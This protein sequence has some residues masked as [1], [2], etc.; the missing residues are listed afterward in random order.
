M[1]DYKAKFEA[2]D[3]EVARLQLELS[4]TRQERDKAEEESRAATAR[5]ER[6]RRE[7]RDAQLGIPAE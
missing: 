2:S 6:L 3:R 5:C 1:I 7:L 4:V